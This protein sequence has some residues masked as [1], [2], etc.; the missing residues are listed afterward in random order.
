MVGLLMKMK[1]KEADQGGTMVGP[2]VRVGLT[3]GGNSNAPKTR[4]LS[5]G[6]PKNY[7]VK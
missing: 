2:F 5:L 1:M 3:S 6:V 4:T 7:P